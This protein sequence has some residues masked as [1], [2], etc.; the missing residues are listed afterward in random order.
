VFDAMGDWGRMPTLVATWRVGT[1]W[2][3]APRARG[4]WLD[5]GAA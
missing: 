2:M 1:L 4:G 5:T 3:S